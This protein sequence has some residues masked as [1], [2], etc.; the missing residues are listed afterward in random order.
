MK[1]HQNEASSKAT[2]DITAVG[3]GLQ[4]NKTLLTNQYQIISSSSGKFGIQVSKQHF[5]DG[6]TDYG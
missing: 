6:S 5:F 4:Y 2:N 3:E 1:S